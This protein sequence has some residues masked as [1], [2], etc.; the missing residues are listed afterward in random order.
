[1]RIIA[2]APVAAVLVLASCESLLPG[3][4]DDLQ[5]MRSPADTTIRVGQAFTPLFQFRG[6]GGRRALEDVLTFDS[7]NDAVLGV[8]SQTGRATAVAPGTANIEVSGATYGGPWPIAVTV[9]P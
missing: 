9:I 8:D 6:C 1:M 3:C 5:V 4:T 2:V 7:T